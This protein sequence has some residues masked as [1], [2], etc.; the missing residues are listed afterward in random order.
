MKNIQDIEV[1]YKNV[2]LSKRMFKV[3]KSGGTKDKWTWH[4]DCL[5]YYH[6]CLLPT[7]TNTHLESFI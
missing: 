7:P 1:I 2:F 5:V 6:S 3:S 4:S